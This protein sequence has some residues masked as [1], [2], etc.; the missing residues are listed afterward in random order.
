[1]TTATIHDQ[2]IREGF[3]HA[4]KETFRTRQ[5]V[6]WTEIRRRIKSEAVEK[7]EL[8]RSENVGVLT[9]LKLKWEIGILLRQ[10][11]VFLTKASEKDM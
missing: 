8:V 10:N 1:M 2:S 3:L 11:R 6:E 4:G 9:C 7:V 5:R